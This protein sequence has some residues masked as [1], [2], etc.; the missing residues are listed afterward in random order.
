VS[1]GDALPLPPQQPFAPIWALEWGPGSG[2]GASFSRPLIYISE[3]FAEALL[4]A[5]KTK[6]RSHLLFLDI[7]SIHNCRDGAPAGSRPCRL[8]STLQTAAYHVTSSHVRAFF[9]SSSII[10]C[11]TSVLLVLRGR[12]SI[13]L[14]HHFPSPLPV[15][16]APHPQS[17][18]SLAG[19]YTGMVAINAPVSFPTLKSALLASSELQL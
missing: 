1:A 7:I 3:P 19:L 8:L 16:F 12:G 11:E 9:L 5:R 4:P 6:R 10:V 14:F 18:A 2:N 13:S 17:R 15:S